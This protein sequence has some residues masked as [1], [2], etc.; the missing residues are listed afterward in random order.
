MVL[1]GGVDNWSKGKVLGDI[2]GETMVVFVNDGNVDW[3]PLSPEFL[4][5]LELDTIGE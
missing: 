3:I 2:T 5:V 1:I 4:E